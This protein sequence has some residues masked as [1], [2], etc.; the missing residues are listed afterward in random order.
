MHRIVALVLV[1]G[2]AA[3]ATALAGRKLADTPELPS[4]DR[5]DPWIRARFGAIASVDLRVCTASDGHVVSVDLLRGS[6]LPAF[7]RAVVTDV[8]AWQFEPGPASCARTTV[9]YHTR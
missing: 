7:D 8:K 3:P 5:I 4:A 9:M 1:L 6:S 2:I